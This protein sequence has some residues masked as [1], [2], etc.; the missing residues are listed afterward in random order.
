[1]IERM[2]TIWWEEFQVSVMKL[3]SKHAREVKRWKERVR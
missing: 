3:K 2:G 1:M